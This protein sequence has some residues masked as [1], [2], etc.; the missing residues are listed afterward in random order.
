MEFDSGRLAGDEGA[1]MVELAL[2]LPVLV[3]FMLGILEY[4]MAFHEADLFERSIN[5]AARTDSNQAK[6][7]LA[8]FNA[9]RSLDSGLSS[10]TRSTISRVIVYKATST[11][12]VPTTC[13]N[14]PVPAIGIPSTPLGSPG[15]CNVYSADQVHQQT[16][17]AFAST[18]GSPDDCTTASWDTKW[19]PFSRV[20]DDPTP[21]S[22]GVWVELN[23]A[24]LTKL[25]PANFKLQRYAV[26]RIEPQ[27]AGGT[28]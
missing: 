1:A 18:G 12:T 14:I 6:N 22:I 7:R 19:C 26:F 20:Q 10:A 25:V 24:N 21:D 9:L 28:Q 16:P 8:D 13:T 5:V 2:I 23:Y 27:S 4:G 3:F 15:L 17:F 11:G